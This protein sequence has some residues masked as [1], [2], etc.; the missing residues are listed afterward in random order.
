MTTA[1]TWKTNSP[2][3]ASSHFLWRQFV[4]YNFIY[5]ILNITLRGKAQEADEL[6]S[7]D[8]DD[9]DDGPKVLVTGIRVSVGYKNSK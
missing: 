8:D 5:S 7:S 2:D 4:Y 3:M 6:Y 1:I 9:A